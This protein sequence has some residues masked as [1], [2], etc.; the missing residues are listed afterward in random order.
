MLELA[1]AIF[2]DDSEVLKMESDFY[3]FSRENE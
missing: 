2:E 3:L 1:P